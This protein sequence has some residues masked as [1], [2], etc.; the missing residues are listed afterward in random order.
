MDIENC[1]I[2]HNISVPYQLLANVK[3]FEMYLI[4]W[5]S[6]ILDS[7][8]SVSTF[9]GLIFTDNDFTNTKYKIC[10]ITNQYLLFTLFR[11]KV[12]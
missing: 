2:M 5:L 6:G 4:T 11:K 1:M 8:V 3:V 12:F 9:Q 10:L 7:D